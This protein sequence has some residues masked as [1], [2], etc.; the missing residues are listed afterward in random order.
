MTRQR[1]PFRPVVVLGLLG[2]GVFAFLLMLYALAQGW[3]GQNERDG[4][5]HA[6]SNGLTGYAG[7]AQMLEGSG[8]DVELSRARSS[9]DSYGLLVLT[10]PLYADPEELAEIIEQRRDADTGPTLVIMPK[11]AAFA[12]PEQMDVEA[13]E[14]WVFISDATSPDWFSDLAFFDGGELAVGETG[15]WNA[16]GDNGSV[17]DGERVQA[18]TEQPDRALGAVVLDSEGDLLAGT[19]PPQWEGG[20]YDYA[21]YPTVVVFEPDLMNNYGLGE[22]ERARLAMQLVETAMGGEPD[23]PVIF[24]LTLPGLGASE[25]LLTLAFR[26][27]FLAATLCLLLAALVIGWRAFRRF[28]PPVAEAPAMA[29]G[30]RQL[31]QNGAALIARVKR[32]H[33]LA[34]PYA[35]LMGKRIA[36]SLGIREANPELRANAIDAALERRGHDGP[37]FAARAD[38]LRKADSPG[39]I[40]RA[41]RALKS[42]ERTLNQ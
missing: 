9:Y 6:A 35:A 28:G 16:F 42:L 29:R 41:A 37:G 5:A 17:P 39:D 2:V 36:D 7:L 19:L 12:I 11:W 38:I 40:I 21:P 14:G 30:K 24:D 31:A 22:Q 33:L 8:Y 23:L 15:G 25:N 13:E 32:F 26:P 1:S 3:T 20:D 34:D 27:P 4:G 10:P 18:L